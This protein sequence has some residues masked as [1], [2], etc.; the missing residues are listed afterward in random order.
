M[1]I[2]W[3]GWEA[4]GERVFGCDRRKGRR[5]DMP[6]GRVG[7]EGR[8][9]NFEMGRANWAAAACDGIESSSSMDRRATAGTWTE[10]SQGQG[11]Q[12]HGGTAPKQRRQ[13]PRMQRL[14]RLH[15]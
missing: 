12:T 11:Q 8:G 14:Q 10:R 7:Q 5:T 15:G 6:G 3:A 9:R 4:R 2:R 1:P 13:L